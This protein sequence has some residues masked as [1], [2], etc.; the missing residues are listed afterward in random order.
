MALSQDTLRLKVTTPFS[1]VMVARYFAGEEGVSTPFHFALDLI[2]ENSALDFTQIVGK[3]VTVALELADGT[4][5]YFHGVCARFV[6]GG[7]QEGVTTYRAELRPWLWM[8]TLAADCKIFQGKSVPDIVEAVFTAAGFS[9]Y[10]SALT[11]TYTALDYCVQY[12]ETAFDFVSRLMEAAGISYFFEHASGKHTLVLADDASAF[13]VCPGLATA[14]YG[15]S[16]T[17]AEMEDT[18]GRCTLEQQVT[19]G[20]LSLDDFNFETPATDLIATVD[21][22]AGTMAVYDYPGGFLTKSDGEAVARLRIE[23]AEA[24]GTVLRGESCCRAFTSGFTFTLAGHDRADVNQSYAL[25]AVTHTADQGGGYSNQFEAV[26]ATVV[27]R[28]PLATPKPRI[29]GAQTALVVGASGEEIYTDQYGRVKVQFHWDQVGTRDEN[30]SCWMRV[31][32]GWAG[33]GWGSIF[34]PRVGMEV[35]VSFIE[36]DPDRPIVSGCVY[37]AQQ[38]VPYALPDGGTRTTFRSNSSKGGNG[39]N[40]IRFEDKAGSEELFI[41]AQKDMNLTVL[42]NC[43]WTI[44]QAH[45][46]TVSEGDETL[47]VSKGSR[48]RTVAEGNDA[49][50]VSKGNRTVTISQGD[51]SLTVSQGKRT[52]AVT[53]GDEDHT[54]GG[55][56]GV[57]VTG[58]ETHKNSGAFTQQ[59]GSGYTLKVTGDIAIE[60]TGSITLKAGSGVTIKAAQALSA[61]GG[62]SVAIKGGQSVGVEA[63]MQLSAK[64][65]AQTSLESGGIMAIKGSLVQIN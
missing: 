19:T 22:T 14:T 35:I 65:G 4:P 20:K 50:T 54:V 61:E 40:E 2:C 28:P 43:A 3:G 31:A 47:A 1:D 57:S 25:L 59:V 64:G 62:Q 18:V 8:L 24:P 23:A 51:E 10:R 63:G 39:F 15:G 17:G 7:S 16:T 26:P 11:G 37:N 49:V 46:V 27:Y 30:S 56:R 58:D 52:L 38:T 33:Q 48:T 36:G 32:Q 12:R 45:Q 9:D 55:K 53:Q 60:A 6:Q 29:A 34:L 5:R 13:A 21:G 42:N 44:T 41:Q